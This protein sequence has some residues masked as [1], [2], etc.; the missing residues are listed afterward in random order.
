LFIAATPDGIKKQLHPGDF[1]SVFISI[2]D[3]KKKHNEIMDKN[4]IIKARIGFE[5]LDDIFNT[6]TELGQNLKEIY[7]FKK[8]AKDVCKNKTLLREASKVQPDYENL[9][10]E[11]INKQNR[12]ISDLYSMID[13][14]SGK[15]NY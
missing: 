4:D 5:F 10:E 6:K 7:E 3:Y 15:L 8:I 2:K 13:E 9:D 11:K 14:L 12:E 1:N